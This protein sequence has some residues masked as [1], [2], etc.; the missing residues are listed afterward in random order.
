VA[1]LEEQSAA[2]QPAR[3]Q[4]AH[5]AQRRQVEHPQ[6]DPQAV[7]RGA[8]V[9]EVV[10]QEPERPAS[11]QLPPAPEPKDATA[12]RVADLEAR[13]VPRGQVQRQPERQL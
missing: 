2:R 8:A 7:A 6:V 12:C 1:A 13:V 9:V 5:P 11:A 10:D 3:N 4:S